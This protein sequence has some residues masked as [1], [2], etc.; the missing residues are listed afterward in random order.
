MGMEK[1]YKQNQ[2]I[3]LT[4]FFVWF[5][6]GATHSSAEELL[7]VCSADTMGYQ[8]WKP[9]LATCKAGAL[10]FQ[11]SSLFVILAIDVLRSVKD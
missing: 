10:S 9:R 4:V 5:G 8:G 2:F 6:L 1:R 7:L 3:V 11:T